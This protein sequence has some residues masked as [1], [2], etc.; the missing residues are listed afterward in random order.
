MMKNKWINRGFKFLGL[1]FLAL[2]VFIFLSYEWISAASQNQITHK[3]EEIK[4]HKAAMV[5]GTSKRIRGGNINLYFK[6]RMQAVKELFDNNKIEYIIVSGDNS[7]KEYNETRDMK[8]YLMDLGVPEERIVEDYAGFSTLD[9]V[10]RTKEVFGQ[11]SIIIVSQP[12]HTERAVFI[13]NHYD[14]AAVGY[15]AKSVSRNYSMKTRAREYLARVKCL[16]DVF[17]LHRMPKFYKEKEAF[18]E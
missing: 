17:I 6:Y 16:L 2:I 18:P 13:A 9:S 1:G 3:I 8:N 15:N 7:V 14:I 10:V 5:L 12:F 4:P 11:D